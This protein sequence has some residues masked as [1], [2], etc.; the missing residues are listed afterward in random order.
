MHVHPTPFLGRLSRQKEVTELF[1]LTVVKLLPQ[2][3]GGGGNALHSK[4]KAHTAAMH[5]AATLSPTLSTC[6]CISLN[7]LTIANLQSSAQ[8][9]ISSCIRRKVNTY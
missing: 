5:T 4:I 2:K 1:V 9:L 3:E 8:Q 7:H 6:S